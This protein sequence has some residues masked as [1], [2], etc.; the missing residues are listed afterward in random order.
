M[1]SK[2]YE[3][4]KF[5]DDVARCHICADVEKAV[6]SKK[7]GDLNAKIMFIAEAPG[8]LGYM[9]T[10]IPL[11][12]DKTGD[13]FQKL[14]GISAGKDTGWQGTKIFVTNAVL[15]NPLKLNKNKTG[16]INAAPSKEHQ[17]HCKVFLNRIIQIINPEIIVCLGKKAA[18]AF[19]IKATPMKSAV[20]KEFSYQTKKLYVLFHPSPR[21]ARYRC[22]AQQQEDWQPIRELLTRLR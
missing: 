4:E 2:E 1:T 13:N 16:K 21:V 15:C 10:E 18:A 20:G 7:N 3:F 22:A 19:D 11:Y 17:A 5:C 12:G 14:L 6:F 8:R 9:K